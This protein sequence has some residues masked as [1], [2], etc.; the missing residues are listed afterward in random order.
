M[1]L[2]LRVIDNRQIPP[3]GRYFRPYYKPLKG[4]GVLLDV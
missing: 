2:I 3:Q 4:I 1:M